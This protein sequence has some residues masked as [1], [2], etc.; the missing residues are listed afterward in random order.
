MAGARAL[1]A[2]VLRAVRSG[3]ESALRGYLADTAL[4]AGWLLA[5]G[6]TLVTLAQ[7]HGHYL[8]MERLRV[9]QL[10]AAQ[11]D[12]RAHA[13]QASL[14]ASVTH[15]RTSRIAS[16]RDHT[17]LASIAGGAGR[18]GARRLNDPLRRMLAE[19]S[20]GRKNS[21]GSRS[22]SHRDHRR[23]RRERRAHFR[24]EQE[25]DDSDTLGSDTNESDLDDAIDT[26]ALE[27]EGAEAT[28]SMFTPEQLT[29]RQLEAFLAA[30]DEPPRGDA[31]L[32]KR[33]LVAKVGRALREAPLALVDEIFGQVRD[34][35]FR[36]GGNFANDSLLLN[37]I[38]SQC[39]AAQGA[40]APARPGPAGGDLGCL[41]TKQ[42]RTLVG[43]LGGS[44]PEAVVEKRELI[45]AAE[46]SLLEA[47]M[48]LVDEVME[49]LGLQG[50]QRGVDGACSGAGNGVD[51]AAAAINMGENDHA[52]P[53]PAAPEP[54]PRRIF[55]DALGSCQLNTLLATQTASGGSGG[56]S[57]APSS[58][59]ANVPSPPMLTAE[60]V[61]I[62]E[63]AMA[64]VPLS[65]LDEAYVE[66]LEPCQGPGR[67]AGR[68]PGTG[69]V[70][71]CRS[72]VRGSLEKRH[73]GGLNDGAT[74]QDRF[75]LPSL[76]PPMSSCSSTSTRSSARSHK[77]DASEMSELWP[78]LDSFRT[79]AA[80]C[81]SISQVRPHVALNDSSQGECTGGRATGDFSE[82]NHGSESHLHL[83]ID[84]ARDGAG[85]R[86]ASRAASR[87]HSP[88][89]HCRATG[90]ESARRC[91][92]R[93]VRLH[94]LRQGGRVA[95]FE[96]VGVRSEMAGRR[97]KLRHGGKAC[98]RS[99]GSTSGEASSSG[100][101]TAVPAD[102]APPE[103]WEAPKLF[104]HQP[105]PK[106]ALPSLEVV[107]APTRGHAIAASTCQEQP[108]LSL[109]TPERLG[110]VLRR[111][112]APTGSLPTPPKWREGDG[113]ARSHESGRGSLHSRGHSR[114]QHAAFDAA[115]LALLHGAMAEAPLALVDE[116]SAEL[117]AELTALE[118][119]RMEQK[120]AEAEARD[121][122]AAAAA[123]AAMRV[124]AGEGADRTARR[125]VR[126]ERRLHARIDKA[127]DSDMSAVDKSRRER[128]LA[129]RLCSVGISE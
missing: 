53:E 6:A 38:P 79:C 103:C 47:P 100:A 22:S 10:Q 83:G 36:P 40:T 45:D 85:S 23:A 15:A 63:A 31:P 55:F 66:S 122:E 73:T 57:G 75:L 25:T 89:V 120:K 113:S 117:G 35:G 78:D 104:A 44:L 87:A 74:F 70:G 13:A 61:R 121:A 24:E 81:L 72:G 39:S 56:G 126:A 119:K 14:T 59:T 4:P 68:G 9:W 94:E 123:L 69:W 1:E 19:N 128:D 51:S 37:P 118:L 116:V 82:S 34:G 97:I 32:S 48:G 101:M 30:L 71:G 52:A 8:L 96:D 107:C 60:L 108:K 50:I 129:R 111:L 114:S 17:N 2:E 98:S 115:L 7:G 125:V 58:G 109:L 124:G 54:A 11:M 20:D 3:D 92:R 42:L 18:G 106:R 65:L 26:L 21:R 112:G 86:A 93:A 99:V 12:E 77:S 110:D 5:N 33:A 88:A 28:P 76:P 90:S 29:V 91:E 102:S 41:T 80:E 27:A 95:S 16:A 105:R 49:R 67:G 62:R 46:C 84:A 43:L 127:L 64:E